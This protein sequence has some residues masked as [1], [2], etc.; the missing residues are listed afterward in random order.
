[1]KEISD[2]MCVV[3][4]AKVPARVS[5]QIDYWCLDCQNNELNG[6]DE[7]KKGERR[8][9]TEGMCKKKKER[10]KRKQ[11]CIYMYYTNMTGKR[12]KDRKKR[13]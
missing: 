1:M 11:S 6:H 2:H 9:R 13:K 10:K 12:K 8:R 5:S 7:R 3:C 4:S